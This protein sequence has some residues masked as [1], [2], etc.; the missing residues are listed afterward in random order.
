MIRETQYRRYRGRPVHPLEEARTFFADQGPVPETL[1]R[2]ADRLRRA[3]IPHVFVGATAVGAHGHQRTTRDVDLC[4]RREGLD[5]FRREHVGDDKEYRPVEG[6]SRRF[7]DPDTG[8]T[9]DILVS[10]EIAGR[11]DKQREVL[12]P[13]PSE[14]QVVNDLPVV[15]LARLVEMKLVTWRLK[16]WADVIE[17]IRANKL[18]ESFADQL[19]PVARAPYLQCFHQMKEEDKYNAI[20]EPFDDKGLS[21]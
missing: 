19:H 1:H 10:G 17:L 3:G 5:L 7:L 14:A 18:D 20:H 12:F 21:R 6:R 16:D 11:S 4:M 15:T 13:E 2:L 9:F 8:V